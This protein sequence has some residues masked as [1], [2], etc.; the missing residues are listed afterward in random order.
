MFQSETMMR[1]IHAERVRDLERAARD[2]RLL[3]AKN[4]TTTPR[5]VPIRPAVATPQPTHGGSAGQPA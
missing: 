4:E 2:H 1:A 5:Q 3:A